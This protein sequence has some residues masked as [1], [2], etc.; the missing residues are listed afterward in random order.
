MQTEERA[1]RTAA[2]GGAAQEAELTEG[3]APQAAVVACAGVVRAEACTAEKVDMSASVMTPVWA[4]LMAA[5]T[6]AAAAWTAAAG[7]GLRAAALPVPQLVQM[8]STRRTAQE[9]S[10][11]R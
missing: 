10:N 5:L 4:S 1:E 7:E 9:A 11:R 3:T 2:E 6:A 8:H